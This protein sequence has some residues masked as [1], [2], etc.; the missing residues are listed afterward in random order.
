MAK[1]LLEKGANAMV[2]DNY[3]WMPLHRALW[4]GHVEVVKLLLEKGADAMVMDKDGWTPLHLASQ[5]D[6]IEVVKMLRQNMV[7]MKAAS[8]NGRAYFG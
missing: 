2:R 5:N 7:E 6:H 8:D 1:L 3:R 4:N